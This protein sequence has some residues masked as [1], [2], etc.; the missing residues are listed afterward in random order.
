MTILT[1]RDA[2]TPD[3]INPAR[4]RR[5]VRALYTGPA[6][7]AADLSAPLLALPDSSMGSGS[8]PGATSLAGVPA[9]VARW[10]PRSNRRGNNEYR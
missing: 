10:G 7:T 6:L 4:A 3:G 5:A 2:P 1:E 9:T 8:L